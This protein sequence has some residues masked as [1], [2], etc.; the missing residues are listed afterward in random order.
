VS[1]SVLLLFSEELNNAIKNNPFLMEKGIDASKLHV[2]FLSEIPKKAAI[3]DLESKS[4]EPDE[5]RYSE[6]R[7]YLYCPNGYGRTKLANNTIEKM[8]SVT[9]TT[10]NWKTVN[11]IY[12]ISIII[13]GR[14]TQIDVE[15]FLIHEP[16]KSLPIID[17][18]KRHSVNAYFHNDPQKNFINWTFFI[19]FLIHF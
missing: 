8:L 2:T 17:Y 14:L 5:F 4:T 9:S 7:I 16:G 6:N 11:E 18:S 1:V 15:I 13:Y 12:G 10:R 3:K 19:L